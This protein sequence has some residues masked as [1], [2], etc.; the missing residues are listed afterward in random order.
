MNL[1]LYIAARY[2][3]S[4]KGHRVI[5]IISGIAVAGV[6]LATIAM[7]CTLSVFNGFKEMVAQQFTVFDADIKITA[8]TGKGFAIDSTRYYALSAL[9]CTSIIT[10]AVE[11]KA[12]VQYEGRQVMA[13]LKGV[14]ENFDKLTD[15][16]S[17]MRGH[18]KFLLHDSICDYALPGVGLL[19]TLN[20]GLFHVKPLEIFAPRRG[21]KVSMANPAANF[22]RGQLH[23]SG[24]IF[25]VNQPKYDDNYILCS[26]DFAR[27]IFGRK[28]NECTSIEIKVADGYSLGKAE[29]EIAAIMGSNYIVE[30]RYKQQ[31][32]VFKVMNIEKFI[33]Y[34]FLSFILLIACFNIIGA[35]SMLII[36]KRKNMETLRAMGASN[37]MISDIFVLEGSM[38]S[39]LGA[40]GG[41]AIGIAV[42][43]LQQEYGIITL[44]AASD[45]FIVD[46]YP[47]RLVWTDI[48]TIFCTV[49]AVGLIAVWVPVRL[50][51]KR[52][53]SAEKG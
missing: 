28:A 16:E 17:A 44:G 10:T 21:S 38:I 12:M 29:K 19:S 1:P 22:K 46:S 18:S 31:K 33:S 49:F 13:N 25:I 42:C 32:D 20:C 45:G 52:Y 41:I 2:L 26:L 50:L 51:T 9:P 34:I 6:T 36:E 43:L 5:N 24:S 7:V 15:I 27:K 3:F 8:A 47:M 40:A 53:I 37:K 23:S 39:L 30:D 35:L 14:E 11:D 48:A 4:K